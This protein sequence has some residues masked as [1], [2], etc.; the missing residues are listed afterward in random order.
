MTSDTSQFNYANYMY[1]VPLRVVFVMWFVY[2]VEIR[3]DLNFTNLGVYPRTGKGLIGVFTGPFIHGDTKHLFNNSIPVFV[4]LLALFYFYEAIAFKVLLWGALLTGIGTWLIGKQ[5]FH[6]G[7]SGVVYLLFGFIFFSGVIRKHFRLIAVSL[8]VIFLYGSMFWY[9]FPIKNG[10]SWEGH[11]S[12]LL[13]GV[14]L[15]WFFRKLGPQAPKHVF[16]ETEFDLLFDEHGNFN[17][18]AP[19]PDNEHDVAEFP[20][21]NKENNTIPAKK[22][23]TLYKSSE[24]D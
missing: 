7:M 16:K 4:L 19:E 8:G 17:P 21:E 6:I 22:S 15:A 13:V 5:A 10:I 23:N 14:S 9:V 20:E 12:G 1:K 3:F 2:W 24:E 11:L 18:P